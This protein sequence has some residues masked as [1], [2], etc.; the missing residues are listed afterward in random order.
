V[1]GVERVEGRRRGGGVE[2]EKFV[3]TI[4]L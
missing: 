2:G 4:I 3:G 1:E